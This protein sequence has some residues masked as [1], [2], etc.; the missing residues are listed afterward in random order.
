MRVPPS[1]VVSA[2]LTD[3]SLYLVF[4]AIPFRALALG[5]GPVALGAIP[6]L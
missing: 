1:L 5:A 3:A 2:F 4:A 6:G